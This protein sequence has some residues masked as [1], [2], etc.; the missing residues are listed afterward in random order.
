MS[1]W[2]PWLSLRSR[3]S[4]CNSLKTALHHHIQRDT[5]YPLHP[6]SCRPIMHPSKC[7]S[8]LHLMLSWSWHTFLRPSGVVSLH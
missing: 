3:G 7:G 5:L 8:P 1:R 6:D 4:R 2:M